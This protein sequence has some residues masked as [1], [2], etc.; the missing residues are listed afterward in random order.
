MSLK[1]APTNAAAAAAA[2]SVDSNNSSVG[3]V[4]WNAGANQNAADV[5]FLITHWLAHYGEQKKGETEDPQRKEA[6]ERIRK[7]TSDIASAFTSL[8]AFGTTFRVSQKKNSGL[9]ACFV[10]HGTI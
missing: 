9:F 6:M 3:S 7:A 5:P 8:G 1:P 2:A 4:G 10:F